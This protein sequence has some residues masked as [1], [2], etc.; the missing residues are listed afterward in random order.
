[1]TPWIAKPIPF[2]IGQGAAEAAIPIPTSGDITWEIATSND[3]T[4]DNNTST[5]YFAVSGF[6]G[7]ARSE[8]EF[9]MGDVIGEITWKPMVTGNGNFGGSGKTPFSPSTPAYNYKSFYI[10]CEGGNIYYYQPQAD[11]SLPAIQI[12]SGADAWDL[13]TVFKLS[14]STT[15]IVTMFK[16]GVLKAT[17]NVAS[18]FLAGTYFAF[19]TGKNSGGLGVATYDFDA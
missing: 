8:E 9:V 17:S 5:V 16:D 3:A 14:M 19:A 10:Y 1:M 7:Y 18:G 11:G 6:T 13:T 12:S 4:I 15:G 2:N